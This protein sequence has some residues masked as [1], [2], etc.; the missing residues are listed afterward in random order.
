MGPNLAFR[1]L[2]AAVSHFYFVDFCYFVMLFSQHDIF[3]YGL[4]IIY[5]FISQRDSHK[6]TLKDMCKESMAINIK[7]LKTPSR[8][9]P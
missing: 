7:Q 4:V 3:I 9:G 6:I 2:S 5:F 1:Y 8:G